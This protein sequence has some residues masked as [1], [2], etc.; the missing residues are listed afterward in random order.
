MYIWNQGAKGSRGK[1]SEDAM[2]ATRTRRNM[3][4][5]RG[6]YLLQRL[7]VLNCRRD[8]LDLR[9]IDQQ[10]PKFLQHCKVLIK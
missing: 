3:F 9:V 7:H 8:P 2:R 5:F 6:A 4:N 10:P 1:D